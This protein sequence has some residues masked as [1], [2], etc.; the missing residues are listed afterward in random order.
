MHA[1]G[2]IQRVRGEPASRHTAVRPGD[3]PIVLGAIILEIER[4]RTISLQR[5]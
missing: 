5:L 1:D 4:G 3:G 2:V